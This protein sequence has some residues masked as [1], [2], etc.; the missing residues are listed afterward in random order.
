MKIYKLSPRVGDYAAWKYSIYRGAVFVRAADERA[1]RLEA[2]KRFGIAAAVKFGE[3]TVA[4]PWT[5]AGVVSAII[6]TGGDFSAKGA[7]GV[8]APKEYATTT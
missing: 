8:L 5:S 3:A 1:A 4:P 7:A 2:Q 6:M